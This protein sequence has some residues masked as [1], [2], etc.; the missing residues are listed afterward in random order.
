MSHPVLLA[1][2]LTG[3]SHCDSLSGSHPPPSAPPVLS[4]PFLYLTLWDTL[5]AEIKACAVFFSAGRPKME[6][7]VCRTLCNLGLSWWFSGY[8]LAL[9]TQG[10]WVQ[11]PVKE[12]EPTHHN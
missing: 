10:A 1:T 5:G 4:R 12:L 11:S 6:V 8:D 3:A 7:S 2:I 9:P